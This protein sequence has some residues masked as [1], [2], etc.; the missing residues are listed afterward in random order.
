MSEKHHQPHLRNMLQQKKTL[1]PNNQ[2]SFQLLLESFKKL[3]FRLLV[4][5]FLRR[6]WYFLSSDFVSVFCR[7]L[8]DLSSWWPIH[9]NPAGFGVKLSNLQLNPGYSKLG[10]SNF[11]STDLLPGELTELYFLRS[12]Y[13][14]GMFIIQRFWEAIRIEDVSSCIPKAREMLRVLSS[15]MASW[16]SARICGYLAAHHWAGFSPRSQGKGSLSGP[17]VTALRKHPLEK[18]TPPRL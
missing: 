15:T 14:T 12:A 3:F 11:F 13:C 6:L 8:S 9:Y 16:L 10:Q 1:A 17:I 5:L 2:I 7:D 18:P 4:F